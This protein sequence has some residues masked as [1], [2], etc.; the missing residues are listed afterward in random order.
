MTTT[1][2]AAPGAAPDRLPPEP[3]GSDT[4]SSVVMTAAGPPRR[5]RIGAEAASVAA[6]ARL[7]A[8]TAAVLLLLF[9]AELATVIYGARSALTVHVAI[10]L[11]LGPP[12]LLKITSTSYRLVQ[13]YRNVPEYREKGPPAAGMRVLAPFLVLLTVGL[14]GS[15]LGLI[16]GPAGWHTGL[17]AVHKVSFYLWLVIVL[18]HTVVRLPEVVRI[19]RH[20]PAPRPRRPGH[21]PPGWV[22][23]VASLVLGGAL[24]LALAGRAAQYAHLYLQR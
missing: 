12:V 6:N 7:T 21:R 19:L 3:A 20:R 8:T 1:G 11:L 4:E 14:L 13:Y 23:V 16:L 17:L 18:T 2:S 10:G 22:A 9:L 24:A 15:G 5:R